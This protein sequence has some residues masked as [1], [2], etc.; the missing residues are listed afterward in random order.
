[1]IGRP[2]SISE[3]TTKCPAG[4]V[5]ARLR[6]RVEARPVVTSRLLAGPVT[7]LAAL[8]HGRDAALGAAGRRRGQ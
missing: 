7:I 1:M 8:A 4:G 2:A 6:G 3:R 5:I